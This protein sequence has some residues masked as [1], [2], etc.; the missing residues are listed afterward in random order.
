MNLQELVN[1][2]L[3]QEIKNISNE[4]I[5]KK[6]KKAYN[7]FY[8]ARRNIGHSENE[9]IYSNI[10]E[11]IRLVGETL[12]LANGWKANIKDHHKTV[13]RVAKLLTN[14]DKKKCFIQQIG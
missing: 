3:L 4:Q 7:F 1:E 11:S 2:N 10:Y 9:I 6:L 13:I 5:K 8:L 14:D 12:L